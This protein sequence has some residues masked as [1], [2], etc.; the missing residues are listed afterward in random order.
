M[1]HFAG[2]EGPGQAGVA[3][4]FQGESLL[5]NI[6]IGLEPRRQQQELRLGQLSRTRQLSPSQEG[7]LISRG[8][9]AQSQALVNARLRADFMRAQQE[10]RERLIAEQR[11]F[12]T[13]EEQRIFRRNR[14]LQEQQQRQGLLGSIFG[15]IAGLGGQF[16]GGALGGPIGAVAG[17]ALGG[18]GG[19]GGLPPIQ[20][21]NLA[22]SVGGFEEGLSF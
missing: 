9:E 4:E 14:A 6:Q 8:Q 13:E 7:F 20:T 22:Q 18:L 16:L 11:R 15:N 17:G 2:H 12:Q 19:G 1:A 5:R 10:Q 3:P 21:P